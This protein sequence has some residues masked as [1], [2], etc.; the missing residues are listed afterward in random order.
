E[1]A[2]DRLGEA[3]LIV[4]LTP[5]GDRL[6]AGE[7]LGRALLDREEL[8]LDPAGLVVAGHDRFLSDLVVPFSPS[9]TEPRR[10]PASST[11]SSSPFTSLF[12]GDSEEKWTKLE[13]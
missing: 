12:P 10:C 7:R 4:R 8:L 2:V 11:P 13:A 1:E 3:R 9:R 6:A 5:E